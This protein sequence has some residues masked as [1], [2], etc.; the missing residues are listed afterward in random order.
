MSRK[1]RL[2]GVILAILMFCTAC[3]AQGGVV[4]KEVK[5]KASTGESWTVMIYMSASV[6]EEKY[7]R[8]GEVLNSLSYDLP[9]NINVLV[10]TGGCRRWS[11]EGIKNDRIQEFEVQKN[12]IRLISE[13]LLKNMG[14]SNNYADFLTRSMKLY[15][16]DNYISVIW[17]EGGGP[18]GGAGYDS[19]FNNDSLSLAE[20]SDALAK[21]CEKIDIFGFDAS[22]MSSLEA[23]SALSLYAD[24]MVAPQDVMPMSGWDYRGLFEYLSQNPSASA[25]M[26]GE[27]ICD[28]VLN[29]AGHEDSELAMM[30]LTDLSKATKLV[31]AFDTTARHM[32]QSAEDI[33]IFRSMME[34][35]SKTR[36]VGAN[37]QWEGYSNLADLSSLSRRVFEATS[38]DAA[39]LDNVISQT[40]VYTA[41]DELHSDMC[42]LNIYYP[43]TMWDLQAYRSVCPSDG[44]TEY[45]D[46]VLNSEN[47]TQSRDYYNTIVQTSS[48]TASADLN[49]VYTLSVTNPEIISRAGVNIYSYNSDE[50]KYMHLVTDYNA[51]RVSDNT[52]T[53]ELTDRQMQINGI[54]VSAHLVCEGEKYSLYSVPVLYDKAVYNIRV[55]KTVSDRKTEYK[56]L[57]LWEG[58]DAQTGI[59]QRRY[60]TLDVGDVIVPIYKIY[61]EDGYIKGK[62]IRLVFGGLNISEKTVVDGD[63]AISYLVEDIY[64]GRT[65]TDAVNVTALNG[66]F[67]VI[68]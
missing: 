55:K 19:S 66:K 23:A 46:K 67:K 37:A 57:G 33:N 58:I 28:G 10:Q 18:L 30:A 59:M 25:Q 61:G 47:I 68:N 24:Y 12:G 53:Y 41:S 13:G 60:K 39:R 45:L 50:G 64:A 38:D 52:F 31:Q 20:I 44:Y 43:G 3:G 8:A 15:P 4:S 54:P 49:G 16:A 22:M 6:M 9:E 29:A 17:G 2:S 63:Y 34:S 62:S 7:K 5:R 51:H 48:A 11:M 56:V 21:V 36:R 65:Q 40:V 1:Y 42:G 32:S 26:V 14:E 35:I 27:V